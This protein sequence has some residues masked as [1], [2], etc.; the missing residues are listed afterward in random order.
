MGSK[1]WETVENGGI[2]ASFKAERGEIRR[3]EAVSKAAPSSRMAPREEPNILDRLKVLL[4]DPGV[5]AKTLRS[6]FD[7][8]QARRLPVL[9]SYHVH[10]RTV[11]E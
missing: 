11:F 8:W 4:A 9:N 3:S 2:F 1:R 6:C 7:A 10:P 5:V